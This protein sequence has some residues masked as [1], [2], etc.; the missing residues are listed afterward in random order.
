MKAKAVL[1]L[2]VLTAVVFTVVS[3]APKAEPEGQ[4]PP[5]AEAPKTEAQPT[6]TPAAAQESTATPVPPAPTKEEAPEKELVVSEL[7]SLDKFDSYRLRQVT[8]WEEQDGESG[9]MEVLTEFVREPMAQRMVFT[10]KDD[11]EEWGME[12]IQVGDTYYMKSDE[13]WIAVQSADFQVEEFGQMWGPE[14]LL[15]DSRGKY[16]GKETVA[17]METKHYRYETSDFGLGIGLSRIKEAEADVWVST[18]HDVHV[19]V[20]MRVVGVDEDGI[21][22]TFTTESYLTD[23]NEPIVIE[24]PEGVAQPGLPDDIPMA[25]GATEVSSFDTMT[26][27]Q[28]AGPQDEMIDFYK[29]EMAANGWKLEESPFDAMMSFT[30]GDRTATIMMAEEDGTTSVTIMVE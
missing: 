5:P 24:A 19:K 20:V 14:D 28:V 15:W 17:G 3:C 23:I 9:S 27:F 12:S 8:S 26:T 25:D 13:E 6:A 21:E 2:V 29:T 30:K 22:G 4:A 7:S 10:G 16:M 1:A 11:G 18:K